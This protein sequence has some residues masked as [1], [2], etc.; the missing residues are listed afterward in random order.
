MDEKYAL[1]GNHVEMSLKRKIQEGDY[2][3]F[4]RLIPRDKVIAQQDERIELVNVNGKPSFR[5]VSDTEF[6]NN[7]G[8]WEQAFRMFSMIYTDAHPHKAKELIQYNHIIYSASLT[9]V[10]S[11][12]Y[13]YDISFRIH[14]SENPGRNWGI[15]LQQAWSMRL[16]ERLPSISNLGRTGGTSSSLIVIKGKAIDT[17]KRSAGDTTGVTVP[18]V[19]TANLITSVGYVTNLDME[20]TTVERGTE[21]IGMIM[22]RNKKIAT[23]KGNSNLSYGKNLC[24]SNHYCVHVHF[25]GILISGIP[26]IP[27]F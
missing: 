27:T 16:K 21:K 17:I 6:I 24:R 14:I 1:V 15:I 3:N 25:K 11:N 10:W 13:A 12:V 22:I 7:F 4:A 19:S 23:G 18:M 26:V 2:V 9:W 5:P 8:K 20:R